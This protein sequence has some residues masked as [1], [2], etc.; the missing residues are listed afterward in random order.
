MRLYPFVLAAALT[1]RLFAA[2]IPPRASFEQALNLH[3]TKVCSIPLLSPKPPL[4]HTPSD[5][6]KILRDPP[7]NTLDHNQIPPPAPPC[8]RRSPFVRTF[9]VKLHPEPKR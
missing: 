7:S 4:A 9:P 3:P 6:A 5:R 1:F 2:E 8:N